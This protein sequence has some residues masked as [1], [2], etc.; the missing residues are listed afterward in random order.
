MRVKAQNE[1]MVGC[2]KYITYKITPEFFRID[3]HATLRH[4]M[5][6]KIPI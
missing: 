4:Q 5:R 1:I 3:P 6:M 2:Y